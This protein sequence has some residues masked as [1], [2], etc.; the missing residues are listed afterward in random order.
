MCYPGCYESVQENLTTGV[1]TFNYTDDT[2]LFQEM[3]ANVTQCFNDSDS[4]S[5]CSVHEQGI[6]KMITGV[7]QSKCV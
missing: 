3:Q 4:V 7:F 1:V 5:D 2:L 6:G